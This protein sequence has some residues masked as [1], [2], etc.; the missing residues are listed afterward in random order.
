M[1]NPV[2]VPQNAVNTQYE[3]QTRDAIFEIRSGRTQKGNRQE[4]SLRT[5]MKLTTVG[6][7]MTIITV[8]MIVTGTMLTNMLREVMS[9]NNVLKR[10]I[11]AVMVQRNKIM[12]V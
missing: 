5:S 11:I 10:N 9:K 7:T 3:G 6:A 1:E 2:C 4:V 8:M 12:T